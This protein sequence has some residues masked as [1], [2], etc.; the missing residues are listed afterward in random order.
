M[1]EPLAKSHSEDIQ[2]AAKLA[3]SLAKKQNLPVPYGYH[4]FQAMLV[5]NRAFTRLD[6]LLKKA[7]SPPKTCLNLL[8]QV[9]SSQAEGAPV[10]KELF[11]TQCENVYQILSPDSTDKMECDAEHALLALSTVNDPIIDATYA[12]AGLNTDSI[13]DAVAKANK[14]KT[15]QFVFFITKEL[16]E[17]LVT[18]LIFLILIRGLVGEFRLIPSTSMYPELQVGDRVAIEATS[19]FFRSYE[20]GD[21]LVFYP[22]MTELKNDPW[23]IFLRMTGVSGLIFKKED[24]IDIA[25]IK[26]LI[27]KPGDTVE[28]VPYQ[29]VK[30]NGKFIDEP[31]VNNISETCT[32]VE[33]P[34]AGTVIFDPRQGVIIG[35]KLVSQSDNLGYKLYSSADK[36][37]KRM[38]YCGPITVPEDQY[39]MMGDNRNNSEDSRFWGFAQKGRVI[40][41]A[42]YRVWPLNR[43]GGLK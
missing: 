19:K 20:R 41:R 4:Y 42:V 18:V 6:S 13:Q 15:K 36:L 14:N 21:I 30:V 24:N 40:G 33:N 38:E 43:A 22:P 28:V 25:Y 8:K 2:E 27:A 16:V 9:L 26:R 12:K 10:T 32:L 5:N 35:G 7:G 37:Y 31:Y 17:I 34:R 29:G 3:Y 11:Y 23:S 39:F 1:A